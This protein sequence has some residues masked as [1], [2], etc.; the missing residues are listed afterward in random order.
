MPSSNRRFVSCLVYTF[1]IKHK[2][3]QII[4]ERSVQKKK[5]NMSDNLIT[6]V[7]EDGGW[8]LLLDSQKEMSLLAK[9]KYHY[10]FCGCSFW[11]LLLYAESPKFD[12]KDTK[13]TC[14][15]DENL[16]CSNFIKTTLE[17]E[18]VL[19]LPCVLVSPVPNQR[20]KTGA[21]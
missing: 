17:G 10:C 3:W 20:F 9:C 19:Q 13:D 16:L 21:N 2:G 14:L 11:K 1:H 4:D 15:P 5:E 18:N 7:A 12:L 8:K 6:Q